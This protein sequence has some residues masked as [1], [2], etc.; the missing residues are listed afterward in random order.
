M[1][2]FIPVFDGNTIAV[3]A[4]G[5]LS[6]E[7]YQNFLPKLEEQIKQFGKVSILF[8][9]EDFSGWDLDSAKDDYD[10]GMQHLDD[11]ERI[12]MVGNKAWERWMSLIAKPFL[13]S[14]EVRYFNH[15]NLQSAWD[16]L[17]ENHESEETETSL[18]P[19]KN[20]VVAVDFSDASKYACERAIELAKL[21]DASLTVLSIAPEY[22]FLALYG[23]S[24]DGYLVNDNMVGDQVERRIKATEAQMSA[25]VGELNA[26]AKVSSKVIYGNKKYSIVSFLEAQKT[27]LVIFAAA[28]KKGLNTLLGSTPQ[29][30][31]NHSR[32]EVLLIPVQDSAF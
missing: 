26:G 24:I 28:K 11:F 12:A 32:A 13:P 9:F 10:F 3:R 4:S 6:H 14:G 2:Q 17:R 23:D 21:Y 7:D 19:Y 30:V 16:W 31:Q 20:I 15:E 29:Y 22:G 18:S 25:F 5:K 27:D 1:L 8:E